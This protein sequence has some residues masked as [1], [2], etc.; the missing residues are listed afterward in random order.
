MGQNLPAPRSDTLVFVGDQ[1]VSW[2]VNATRT[3]MVLSIPATGY[4]GWVRVVQGTSSWAGPF[5]KVQGT[6]ATYVGVYA[7]MGFPVTTDQQGPGFSLGGGT[8]AVDAAGNLYVAA[9]DSTGIYTTIVKIAP[10]GAATTLVQ[11]DALVRGISG[12]AVDGAGNVYGTSRSD[13]RIVRITPAGVASIFAGSAT[14]TS[15]AADGPGAVATFYDPADIA[16]DASDNLYVAEVA[17]NKI[18]K[19]TPTGIVST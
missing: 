4:G 3:Q 7:G 19:I 17:N 8:A 2:T 6:V 14:G 18:R 11:G 1:P 9:G 12:I 5:V 15:G 13:H 10:N 16:S